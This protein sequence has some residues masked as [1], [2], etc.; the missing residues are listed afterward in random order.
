MR[1]YR[2]LVLL[3]LAISVAAEDRHVILISLDGLRP[4]FYLDPESVGARAPH[5]AALRRDGAWVE[6]VSPVFPSVTYPN[7][8]SLVTG[9]RPAR[10]GIL[11]NTM[12]QAPRP[13]YWYV[14][15]ERLL[16]PTLWDLVREAGHTTAAIHWPTT[17]GA[18]IDVLLPE[19]DYNPKSM[20][21]M[22]KD[23]VEGARPAD[24][25]ERI[26]ARYGEVKP[27]NLHHAELDRLIAAATCVAIEQHKPAL[28]LVH[29]LQVDSVQHEHG[30]D[31][32]EV[33]E[34]LEA[35]DEVLGQISASI[36]RAGIADSTTIIVCGDHGF[37]T[38]TRSVRP[39]V[40]LRRAGLVTGSRARE[41]RVRL[42]VSGNQAAV[43]LADPDDDALREAAWKALK[44]LSEQDGVKLYRMLSR[45]ELDELGAHPQAAFAIAAEEGVTIDPNAAEPFVRDLSA[46]QGSHGS[47][48]DILDLHTGL[49]LWGRGVKRGA[50][51]DR[52]SVLDVAPTTARLLGIQ[53]EDVEGRVL[54]ELLEGE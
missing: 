8:A 53:M 30:R 41:W 13:P 18:K 10:H 19:P 6:S 21:R 27:K 7:H 54:V 40:A 2:L 29:V 4:E 43:Y 42:H 44:D 52:A 15:S 32:K 38:V 26:I 11:A 5:L 35:A 9:V 46:P 14:D 37:M 17:F 34:A 45:Q 31:G 39:A 48:P 24:Y 3:A 22:W 36:E 33:A 16:A 51:L 1:R 25:I 20:E 12:F 49:V 47:H 23:T 28:V 50:R